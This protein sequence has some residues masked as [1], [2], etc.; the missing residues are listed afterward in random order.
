[1]KNAQFLLY[2]HNW[3]YFT[4]SSCNISLHGLQR[5]NCTMTV[6]Q[7][8]GFNYSEADKSYQ[9]INDIYA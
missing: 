5:N 9:N 8:F 2:K 3:L 1:M 7:N 6:E 4:T